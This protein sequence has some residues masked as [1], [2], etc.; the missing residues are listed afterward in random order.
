M[1]DFNRDYFEQDNPAPS[2]RLSAWDLKGLS[3]AVAHLIDATANND[4][5]KI[6]TSTIIFKHHARKV[7]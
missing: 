1:V 2:K 4:E 5:S 6:E 7:F 3:D